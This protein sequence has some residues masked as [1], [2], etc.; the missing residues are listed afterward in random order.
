M[1]DDVDHPQVALD[2]GGVLVVM[3]AD[4]DVGHQVAEGG[5]LHAGLT[6]AGEH[7]L[8]VGQEQP[9]GADHQHTLTFERKTVR[10]EQVR[11]AVQGDHC[12]AGAGPSLHDEDA[13]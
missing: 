11:G 3:A 13:G 1:A 5:D 8:D 2:P 6:Q 9:V 7:L 10:V 12:L 4:A